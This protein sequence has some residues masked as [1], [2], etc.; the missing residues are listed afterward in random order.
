MSFLNL[1]S[2]FIS[3]RNLDRFF[4]FQ[5]ICSSTKK[6]A[7][8]QEELVSKERERERESLKKEKETKLV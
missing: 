2:Y 6:I 3:I 7:A 1:E 5:N 8:T 4:Q